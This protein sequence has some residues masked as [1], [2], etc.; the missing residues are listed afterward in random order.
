MNAANALNFSIRWEGRGKEK[1]DT[2]V[3][4]TEF[5]QRVLEVPDVRD[6]AEFEKPVTVSGRYTGP[7]PKRLVHQ[8]QSQ[9]NL[10]GKSSR[11]K[12]TQKS[13]DVYVPSAKV[14]VEQKT[15]GKDL[16]AS[17]PQSDGECL[18]PVE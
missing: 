11:R 6:F 14:I 8:G 2:V 15:L 3:F 10:D 16:D 13:I 5:F 7:R 18:T 9:L 1:Q 12:A 17:Y 4:W